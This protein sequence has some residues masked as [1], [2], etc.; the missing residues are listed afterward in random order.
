MADK[1]NYSQAV[2]IRLLLKKPHKWRLI[3][4][5]SEFSTS[6]ST[7]FPQAFP[8]HCSSTSSASDRLQHQPFVLPL[9]KKQGA[10]HYICPRPQSTQFRVCF[11]CLAESAV[12]G[13]CRRTAPFHD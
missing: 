9:M 1:S 5:L 10:D 13:P 7:S 4:C 6:F 12:F 3:N 11:I 2:N 8:Q